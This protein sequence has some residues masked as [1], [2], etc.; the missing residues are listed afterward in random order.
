MVS[1]PSQQ[2]WAQ[3]GSVPS[4]QLVLQRWGGLVPPLHT[5]Q[6]LL[7]RPWCQLGT[8]CAHCQL[9]A[10]RKL[11]RGWGQTGQLVAASELVAQC[12]GGFVMW[13][14]EAQCLWTPSVGAAWWC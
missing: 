1:L 9:G 13:A 2:P 10:L 6:L 7:H 4:V 5:L 12:S 3:Q 8:L 11:R 14:A